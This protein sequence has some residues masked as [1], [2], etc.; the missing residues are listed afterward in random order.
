MRTTWVFAAACLLL[1]VGCQTR[2]IIVTPDEPAGPIYD[3]KPTFVQE[4]IASWYGGRWIGRLTANGERYKAGDMT[5]A[6]KT[7]PFHT[8]VRVVDLKT[9][10]SVIVRINNRGPYIRGRII[11]LSVAAARKLG[12]YDRGIARV[13]IEALRE[14]P[15]MRKPN[16]RVKPKPSPSPSPTPNRRR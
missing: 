11:D 3:S 10:N 7:L 13:R 4:G 6:H 8:M 1:L 2:R 14:I 9:K 12:T 15:V 16:V 5:A